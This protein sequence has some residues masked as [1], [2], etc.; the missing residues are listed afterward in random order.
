MIT[1]NLAKSFIA[2]AGAVLLVSATMAGSGPAFA[3]GNGTHSRTNRISEFNPLRDRG[4]DHRR[5]RYRFVSS[6]YANADPDCRYRQT[7]DGLVEIC[8]QPDVVISARHFVGRDPDARIRGQML[9][10]FDRGAT[11]PGGR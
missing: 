5:L 7:V 6:G 10:D 1:V 8:P 3:D 9:N 11:F 4:D 2:T